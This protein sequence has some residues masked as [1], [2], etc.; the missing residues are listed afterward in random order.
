MSQREVRFLGKRDRALGTKTFTLERPVGF[1][2]V[3]GQFFFLDIPAEDPGAAWLT[4][5]FT[6][7]SSPTEQHLELTTRMT[8][9]PFKDR[10]DDLAPQTVVRIDGPD[11][12]FT[13]R[14]DMK[15]V[16]YVCGG[17]GITPARS[18]MRWALDT[19][20]DVDIVVLYSNRNVESIMFGDEFEAIK[21]DRIRIV[22]ILSEPGPA[23]RG[24]AG[25]MDAGFIHAEVPDFAQRYFFVSGPPGMVASLAQML[26]ADVGIKADQLVTEDFTGYE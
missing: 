14:P 9:H 11:G 21:S 19:E 8:G 5:H 16:C 17:I 10:L 7:S 22:N 2:Y 23:W 20:A 1:D 3:A 6:L 26:S 25:R 4:H 15:K 24:P 13:L 12:S 18:T